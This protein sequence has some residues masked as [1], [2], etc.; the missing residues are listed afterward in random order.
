MNI[1]MDH[2]QCV[3]KQSILKLHPNPSTENRPNYRFD[4]TM[5]GLKIEINKKSQSLLS[6]IFIK[7]YQMY[8]TYFSVHTLHILPKILISLEPGIRKS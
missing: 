8:N 4:S 3:H 7:L 5:L 6:N 1:S 2:C